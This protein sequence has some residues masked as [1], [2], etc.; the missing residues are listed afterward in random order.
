MAAS[1]LQYTPKKLIVCC[2][3]TWRNSDSGIFNGTV[4]SWLWKGQEQVNTNVTRIS[5]AIRSTDSQGRQQIVYYQAGVGSEGNLIERLVGGALGVGLAANIREAYSFLANNYVTGDEI[6]LIG[7]SRGAFT[8]R[9]I[10]GLISD[11]GLLTTEGMNN[12][13][14]SK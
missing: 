12:L 2:D 1:K 10:G 7:F 6:C 4:L 11:L 3:G 8:A 5:R 13:V 9:S 14:D